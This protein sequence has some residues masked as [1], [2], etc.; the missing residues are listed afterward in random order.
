MGPKEAFGARKETPRGAD[1]RQAPRHREAHRAG[2]VPM[3]AKR[4]RV[5]DLTD[6]VGS[7]SQTPQPR[8]SSRRVRT[9]AFPF[10]RTS[11]ILRKVSAAPAVERSG[12]FRNPRSVVHRHGKIIREL[13]RLA[14]RPSS[15][16][17]QWFC[18][19]LYPERW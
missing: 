15:M 6:H 19:Y 18:N 9:P 10:S 3:A 17:E 4:V 14:C 5:T 7:S 8:I 2:H 11:E 13:T 1:H 12:S 16:A